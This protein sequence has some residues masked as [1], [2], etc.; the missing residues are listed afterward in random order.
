MQW[1]YLTPDA[2]PPPAAVVRTVCLVVDGT[3]QP[4][5]NTKPN[6]AST[7]TTATPLQF[8]DDWE[9]LD[10]L[11]VPPVAAL[12]ARQEGDALASAAGAASPVENDD[13]E[14]IMPEVTPAAAV[15]VAAPSSLDSG[16]SLSSSSSI[17]R[18]PPSSSPQMPPQVLSS[19]T[20]PSPSPDESEEMVPSVL[21][22]TGGG[23]GGGDGRDRGDG[24]V[25]AVALP[26]ATTSSRGNGSGS[27]NVTVGISRVRISARQ[28]RLKAKE[29]AVNK[30]KVV[31]SSPAAT[32][33]GR[34][35]PAAAGIDAGVTAPSTPSNAA[36]SAGSAAAVRR[37]A[38]S[39]SL[40]DSLEALS[41]SGGAEESA[42]AEAA[43]SS[44]GRTGRPIGERKEEY[45]FHDED[46][47]DDEG[48][49]SLRCLSNTG[50]NDAGSYVPGE[51]AAEQRGTASGGSASHD[52]SSS[53]GLGTDPDI[54]SES[55]SGF[56]FTTVSAPTTVAR[57]AGSPNPP[58]RRGPTGKQAGSGFEGGSA[59]AENGLRRLTPNGGRAG[60]SKLNS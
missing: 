51:T 2:L 26:V 48:G 17:S 35:K 34:S 36:G 42:V 20:L 10:Q 53:I 56:G 47:D 13:S 29:A 16:R 19:S 43:P 12:E 1:I 24:E 28:R 52:S 50:D 30:I 27:D 8:Q 4:H 49:N 54:G 7:S 37:P 57:L 9:P 41:F 23:G 21:V 44:T 31:S 60:R 3:I 15:T 33:P 45:R 59:R 32:S 39:L 6:P 11:P 46:D 14:V 5:T 22:Q 18:V 25:S 38:T 55:V 40:M 58:L